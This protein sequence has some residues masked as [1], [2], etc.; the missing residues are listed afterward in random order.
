MALAK[1]KKVLV[2]ADD[3]NSLVQPPSGSEHA[4]DFGCG[5]CSAGT[6]S[7]APGGPVPVANNTRFQVMLYEVGSEKTPVIVNASV[8]Q[9]DGVRGSVVVRITSLGGA[10]TLAASPDSV[11]GACTFLNLATGFISVSFQL[12]RGVTLTSRLKGFW[13][14]A[15]PDC[16]PPSRYLFQR[17]CSDR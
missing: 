10:S 4:V 17:V 3:G 14:H 6:E 13:V 12:L 1:L 5:S 15:G 8:A 7:R 11:A 9:L 16:V 2:G